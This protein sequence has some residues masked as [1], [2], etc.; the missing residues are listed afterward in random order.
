MKYKLVFLVFILLLIPILF[1]LGQVQLSGPNPDCP[2]PP[3]ED[4][5][6]APITEGIIFL[7]ISAVSLGIKS[8]SKKNKK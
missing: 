7:I 1:T 4:P 5:V 6:R 2:N 3:C 8:F